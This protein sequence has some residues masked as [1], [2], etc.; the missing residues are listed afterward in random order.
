ML[1]ELD[2]TLFGYQK[3]IVDHPPKDYKGNL[4]DWEINV[5]YWMAALR[6][7]IQAGTFSLQMLDF[8]TQTL[9]T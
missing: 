7:Q 6:D 5:I 1:S 8:I 3:R 9:E 4:F 2:R